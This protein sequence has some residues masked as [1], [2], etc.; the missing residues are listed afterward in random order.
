MAWVA[1][2]ILDETRSVRSVLALSCPR[3]GS[4]CSM[5]RVVS[6]AARAVGQE[7]VVATSNAS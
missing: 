2:P 7:L 1:V 3:S 6:Q 5:G 4:T